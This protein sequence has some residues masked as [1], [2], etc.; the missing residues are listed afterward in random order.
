M[1]MLSFLCL[2]AVAIDGDTLRCANIAEANGR[3]RIARIDTPERW[4]PGYHEATD[5][6]AALIAGRTVHCREV[7]ANPRRRGYQA[8]DPYGRI[9]ATCRAGGRALGPAMLK[10]GAVRWGMNEM[11]GSSG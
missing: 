9:V 4:Q 7:D 3:V 1:G 2:A 10:R 5:A 11:N 6:L 8:R